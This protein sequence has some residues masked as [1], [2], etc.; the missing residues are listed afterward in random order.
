M[1][2]GKKEE[3]KRILENLFNNF[4]D[5][6][7]LYGDA[8]SIYLV[9]NMFDDAKAVFHLYKSKFGEELQ[10]DFSLADI[11]QEENK[12]V[13]SVRTYD[14][15]AV[16]VFR[17]MSAFERGRLSNLPMLLPVKEI[18]LSR[19][20]IVLRKGGREYH[21][22]WPEIQDAFITRREGSKGYLFG[23]EIIRTLHLRTKDQTFKIDVSANFPDFKDNEVLLE[24]MQK[25]IALREEK[26]S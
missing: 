17:R 14:S 24:E 18:R 2:A 9:G 10:S 20:K 1:A 23:E 26:K 19:D 16:K 13:S 4:S 12:Y 7:S 6:K 22:L 3:A 11:E 25:R 8:V 5:K 21:Y 15:A